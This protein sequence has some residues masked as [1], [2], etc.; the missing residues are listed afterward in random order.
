MKH[1]LS[2]KQTGALIFPRLFEGYSGVHKIRIE[3]GKPLKGVAL[4]AT[5]SDIDVA[6][7]K[8][9]ETATGPGHE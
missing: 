6:G 3:D 8:G 7:L 9:K 4:K 1:R 2:A 5:M